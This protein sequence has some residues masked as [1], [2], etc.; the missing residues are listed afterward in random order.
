M[1]QTPLAT[2]TRHS[3]TRERIATTLTWAAMMKRVKRWA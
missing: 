1:T 2:S 3:E